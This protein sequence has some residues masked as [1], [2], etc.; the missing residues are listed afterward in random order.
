MAEPAHSAAGPA[1]GG[2]P[3]RKPDPRAAGWADVRAAV[4][5]DSRAIRLA[6]EDVRCA[7]EKLGRV[8]EELGRP[9]PAPGALAAAAEELRR[10]VEMEGVVAAVMQHAVT[11]TGRCAANEAVIELTR[12]QAYAEGW[13]ACKAARGRLGV[14]GGGREG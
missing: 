12:A 7:A 4:T 11:M 5:L 1:S 6:A 14:V 10:A 2:D 9:A 3:E 13:E 8:L